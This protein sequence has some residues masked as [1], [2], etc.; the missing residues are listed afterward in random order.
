M[1]RLVSVSS[2]PNSK[3]V[4]IFRKKGL[5]PIEVFKEA[6][7]ADCPTPQLLMGEGRHMLHFPVRTS[8]GATRFHSLTGEIGSERKI[9]QHRAHDLLWR[10]LCSDCVR[11]ASF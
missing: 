3:Q 6:M 11:L 2:F 7:G 9:S 8:T 5:I 10:R 4:Y 1:E